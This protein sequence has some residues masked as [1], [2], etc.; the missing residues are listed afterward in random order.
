MPA[1]A[2]PANFVSVTYHY[3][4]KIA[5][6]AYPELKGLEFELFVEQVEFLSRHFDFISMAD[7]MAI[8]ASGRAPAT[9]VC[10]LTFDDGFK[11]HYDYCFAELHRR[12]IPGA[13]YPL[14]KPVMDGR[15]A[16][17]HRIHFMLIT[18]PDLNAVYDTIAATV[19]ASQGEPGVATLA[20]Y[21]AQ[22]YRP[23]RFDGELVNFIKRMLQK[24][25]PLKI[26]SALC[27]RLFRAHVS[28]DEAGFARS[29]YMSAGELREMRAGGMHI[30][31]HAY[32]H[33]WLGDMTPAAQLDEITKAAAMMTALDIPKDEWTFCYPYGSYNVE[34]LRIVRDFGFR[35]GWTS[36]T[37]FTEASPGIMELDRFDTNYV[38]K[39]RDAEPAAI[40]TGH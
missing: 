21:R 37:G 6:S 4:R 27:E 2:Q 19:E 28:D 34:T 31:S 11:D 29:L 33:E 9:P 3:V 32:A 13:F 23:N 22:Y 26:R 14:A 17:V 15:L 10:M 35:A 30:G 24:A 38:P 20:E 7:A 16:D 40:G 5:G 18:A 1:D 8:I 39:R 36:R 12:K 25:L